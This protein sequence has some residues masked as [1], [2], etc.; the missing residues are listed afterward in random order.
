[1]P[2]FCV[3][4]QSSENCPKTKR[5]FPKIIGHKFYQKHFPKFYNFPE[6]SQ[7]FESNLVKVC[8]QFCLAAESIGQDGTILP[9]NQTI[10]LRESRGGWVAM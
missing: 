9:D 5:E 2:R 1:M 8:F 6:F 7:N 10:K 3:D 4:F